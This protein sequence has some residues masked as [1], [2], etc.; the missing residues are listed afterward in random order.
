MDAG[1][2][3]RGSTRKQPSDTAVQADDD[4]DMGAGV[5]PPTAAATAPSAAGSS[6]TGLSFGLRPDPKAP[7]AKGKAPAKTAQPTEGAVAAAVTA[8]KPSKAAAPKPTETTAATVPPTAAA[9]APAA[10]ARAG[11]PANRGRGS[12]GASEGTAEIF[13]SIFGNTAAA[14]TASAPVAGAAAEGGDSDASSDHAPSPAAGSGGGGG[15][16]R[17]RRAR[18]GR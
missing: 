18:D 4:V 15:R 14:D 5:V 6:S 10:A 12:T 7:A 3:S 16:S 9:A 1:F 8:P 17:V 11:R 2:F 13:S